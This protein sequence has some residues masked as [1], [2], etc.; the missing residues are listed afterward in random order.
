[1]IAIL[2]LQNSGMV[3]RIPIPAPAAASSSANDGVDIVLREMK[4]GIFPIIV[5]KENSALCF[6][7]AGVSPYLFHYLNELASSLAADSLL[8]ALTPSLT[9]RHHRH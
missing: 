9:A 1:M 5:L 7:E 6:S 4:I 8:Q 3:L 2:A